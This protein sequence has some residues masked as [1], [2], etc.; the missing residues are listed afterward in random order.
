MDG[1]ETALL[2]IVIN[3]IGIGKIVVAVLK[4]PGIDQMQFFRIGRSNMRLEKSPPV[5]PI[6]A[7]LA[8]RGMYSRILL[9]SIGRKYMG[10]RTGIT[11]I[12]GL[13]LIGY[14]GNANL[15]ITAPGFA[16]AGRNFVDSSN[17]CRQ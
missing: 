4:P 15:G 3:I 9:R 17:L 1:I 7:T 8:R 14:H 12:N 16:R 2:F 5:T 6:S 10:A 13:I 11:I